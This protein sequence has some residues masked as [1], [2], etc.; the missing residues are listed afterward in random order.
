MNK[1][2]TDNSHFEAKVQLRIDHL[3]PEGAIRV[4]DCFGGKGRIWREIRRQFPDK[5]IEVTRVEIKK[6]LP[7]IYLCGD[8]RKYLATLDLDR[9]NVID[10]D[11]Y[12]VPFDQLEILF[13][14][15]QRKAR[16]VFVTIC[17]QT[18]RSVPMKMLSA[19]GYPLGMVSKCPGLFMQRPLEK[20][21][22]YLYMRGVRMIDSVRFDGREGQIYCYLWFELQARD[23]GG[24][25]QE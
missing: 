24:K 22:R 7:G 15:P 19:V 20:F 1:G 9:Y 3:P 23:P 25:S 14:R 8:N 10:L 5:K 2:K 17:Q 13:R 18:W 16:V 6:G 12:G 21:K 11:A 4:L